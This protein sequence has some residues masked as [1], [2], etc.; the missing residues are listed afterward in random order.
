MSPSAEPTTERKQLFGS[1]GLQALRWRLCV[2][3]GRL[4]SC[5]P[6]VWNRFVCPRNNGGWHLSLQNPGG[7]FNLIGKRRHFGEYLIHIHLERC[8]A[9][10][11]TSGINYTFSVMVLILSFAHSPLGRFSF[12]TENLFYPPPLPPA[13]LL[14]PSSLH[15]LSSSLAQKFAA[16]RPA[17]IWFIKRLSPLLMGWITNVFSHFVMKKN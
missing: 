12:S 13:P 7:G 11:Y 8:W 5:S 6:Q 2:T 17:R 1:Q 3:R 4:L 14:R 9:Q 15:S 10:L 16:P